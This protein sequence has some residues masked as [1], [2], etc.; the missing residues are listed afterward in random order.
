MAHQ[1]IARYFLLRW[2]LC[3]F[4]VF[5]T[6]N[7]SGY[8]YYYWLQNSGDDYLAIK[9]LIFV[10]LFWTYITIL[11]IARAAVGA[12]GLYTAIVAVV[13][14]FYGLM[15]IEH[16]SETLLNFLRYIQLVTLASA[17]AICLTW[18]KLRSSLIGQKS[19]RRLN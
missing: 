5:A 9:A 18:S 4:V 10:A 19:V 11:S 15:D 16:S 7:P 12:S 8:S 3:A 1:F 6:Y 13:L 2:L 14:L 17:L